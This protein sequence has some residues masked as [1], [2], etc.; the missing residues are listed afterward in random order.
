MAGQ[1]H[2]THGG[3]KS[4]H[5]AMHGGGVVPPRGSCVARLADVA[6]GRTPPPVTAGITS[7]PP[8]TAGFAP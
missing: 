3:A 8:I 6:W 1:N 2:C 7:P 4:L 5:P